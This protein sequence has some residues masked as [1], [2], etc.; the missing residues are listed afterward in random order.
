MNGVAE[1]A[2]R[3]LARL[4]QDSLAA[5]PIVKFRSPELCFASITANW[6]PRSFAR[7]KNDRDSFVRKF[8]SQITVNAAAAPSNFVRLKLPMI[9]SIDDCCREGSAPSTREQSRQD[10][11][12]MTA[13]AETESP[14]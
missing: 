12:P 1:I 8:F 11:D 4:Q 13:G 3:R 14:V 9:D 6:Q 7:S 5:R 10:V 2:T